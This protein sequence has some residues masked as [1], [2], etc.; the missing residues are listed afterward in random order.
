V[1]LDPE[2]A[3][4]HPPELDGPEVH[5]PQSVVDFLESDVLA[6]ERLGD[7]GV[8]GRPGCPE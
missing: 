7:A 2:L 3:F 1:I 5:V 4:V 6:A 8:I